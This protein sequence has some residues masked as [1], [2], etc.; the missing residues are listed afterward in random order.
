MT[1]CF[2]S[3]SSA[4]RLAGRAEGD[5]AGRRRPRGTRGTGVSI[6]SNIDR[7]GRIERRD[8]R[9]PDTA[10]VEVARHG[11]S[12][13]PSSLRRRA[14]FRAHR[15]H[16]RRGVRHR[17]AVG[18]VRHRRRGDLEPVVAGARR[19]ADRAVG[20]TLPSIIPSAISGSLRY[21]RDG[22]LRFNVIRWVGPI[23]R[24]V[25]DRRG[26]PL[27]SGAGRRPLADDERRV[28]HGLHRDPDRASARRGAAR[29]RNRRRD[30]GGRVRNRARRGVAARS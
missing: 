14:G 8:Q 24:A 9:N 15:P 26:A 29:S 5:D 27:G 18:H 1:A 28:A 6:A 7:T 4:A 20:S 17:R 22:L 13:D 3:S 21:R 19:G 25:F 2:S 30:G 10:Q 16:C 12:L 23:G 11:Q